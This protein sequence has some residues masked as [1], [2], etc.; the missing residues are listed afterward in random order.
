MLCLLI[1]F[2]FKLEFGVRIY[3]HLNFTFITI[4]YSRAFKLTNQTRK[5]SGA[6]DLSGFFNRLHHTNKKY[7]VPE[8]QLTVCEQDCG[9]ASRE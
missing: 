6:M 7:T 3:R 9:V 8:V 1:L 5:R 2:A 4:N